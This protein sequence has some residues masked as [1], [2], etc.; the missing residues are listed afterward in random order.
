MIQRK[1]ESVCVFCG[2]SEGVRRAYTEQGRALGRAM[3]DRG[4]GLVYG[5]GSIGV[6]GAVAGG[7]IERGGDLVGVIPYALATRERMQP[8]I[9]M[10]IVNTMHERKALMTEMA[11]AFIILPG[12]FGTFDEMFEIITWAQLGIHRKPIGLLDVE[13]YFDPLLAM[14]DHSID[15]GFVSPRFRELILISSE[16][17]ELLARLT[18]HPEIEGVIKWIDMEQV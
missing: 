12:G 2:S 15:E 9:E 5:G 18:T 13:G 7:V 8:N 3:A 10:R 14:I 17:D 11:D 16:I 6:M 4:I 1:I